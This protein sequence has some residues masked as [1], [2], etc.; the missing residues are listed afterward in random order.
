MEQDTRNKLEMAARVREFNR[1]HP[2]KA[3]GQ[4]AAAARLETQLDRAEVLS[5]Q[6]VTGYDTVHQ[7]V[8]TKAD[9]KAGLVDSLR[10]LQGIAKASVGETPELE[11]RY[12]MPRGKVAGV[13][14]ITLAKARHASAT[15]DREMLLKYGMSETFL[16]ELAALIAQYEEAGRTKASGQ[17]AHVGATADLRELTSQIMR[18]VH[19]MDILNRHRFRKDAELRAAWKSARNVEWPA[20]Q[21]PGVEPAA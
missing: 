19:Q 11:Q 10:L 13:A 5:Q 21:R 14:L 15:T 18:T 3:P 8:A 20:H 7:S 6:V 9:L 4:V 2:P 16:D 1:A 17:R 12:R